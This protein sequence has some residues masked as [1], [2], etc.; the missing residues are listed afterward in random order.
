[1]NLNIIEELKQNFIYDCRTGYLKRTTRKNSNGSFDS[2]GYLIIK[3]KGKQFKAH[4]ICWLLHYGYI[5]NNLVIDHIN[6]NVS[7]NRIDNLRLVSIEENNKNTK[8]KG[9]YKDNCTKQLLKKYRI[10]YKNN[11]YSFKTLD[12]A[13]EKRKEIDI[14]NKFIRRLS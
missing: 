3:Y 7:D 11:T 4:R 8:A 9:I 6:G 10:R 5:D 12:E 1:M 14:K 2:K 13:I